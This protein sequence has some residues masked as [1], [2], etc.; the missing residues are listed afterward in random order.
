M[1]LKRIE[2]T[3]L[4]ILMMVFILGVAVAFSIQKPTPYLPVLNPAD[5]EPSGVA[6]SLERVGSG[7]VVG[8]FNLVNQ[9]GESV[10]RSD[11][12]G[13]IRV[14]SYFFTTCPGICIDMTA[15][16]KLVQAAFLND[17]RVMIM[18]HSATPVY[19]SVP[20]LQAYG[21]AN[22]IDPQRWWLLTGD[23]KELNTLA[24]TSYFTVLEEGQGWDEHSFIH[25]ENLVL[26]DH[27]GQLRGYYDGTREDQAE[28]L[29]GHIQYLIDKQAKALSDEG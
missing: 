8:E 2:R 16:L 12:D 9:L 20:V 29:I 13:K 5:I 14:V 25:T 4:L 15:N 23:P 17:H 7:H 22:G 24:R 1:G 28:M 3:K 26:I 11:V 19:D 10:S 21:E 27:K 6:D 18:S